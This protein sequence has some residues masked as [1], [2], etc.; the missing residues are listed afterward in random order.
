MVWNN[1]NLLSQS[2]VGYKFEYHV[3]QLVSLHRLF[4]AEIKIMEGLDF[5][6]ENLGRIHFQVSL[7]HNCK[8]DVSSLDLGQESFSVCRGHLYSQLLPFLHLQ[9]QQ[10]I[11][12]SYLWF[13]SLWLILPHLFLPLFPADWAGIFLLLGLK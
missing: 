9:S 1:R 7:P 4:K 5:F 12:R 2:S 3:A 13:D 11:S 10:L 8:W 6:R